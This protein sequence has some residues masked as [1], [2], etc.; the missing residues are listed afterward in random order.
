VEIVLLGFQLQCFSLRSKAFRGK[1]EYEGLSRAFYAN[2]VQMQTLG[3]YVRFA[4]RARARGLAPAALSASLLLMILRSLSL[5]TALLFALSSY[6]VSI[7]RSP[8]HLRHSI[9]AW[10]CPLLPLG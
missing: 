10:A 4:K 3:V 7:S 9:E 6:W 1:R 8:E 5:L 2:E